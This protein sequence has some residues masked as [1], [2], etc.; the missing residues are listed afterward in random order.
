MEEPKITEEIPEIIK[1]KEVTPKETPKLIKPEINKS[2][3]I[4]VSIDT[5]YELPSYN[6]LSSEKDAEDVEVL[7]E[8]PK[9]EIKTTPVTNDNL[10]IESKKEDKPKINVDVDS[11]VVN[12]NIISDDEF[13]DD[14]FG[15]DD[16]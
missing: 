9:T 7:D 15:D 14:F 12:N 13:F 2:E 4:K 1:E 6:D 3:P 8:V 5:N 10:V 16:Y 11:V